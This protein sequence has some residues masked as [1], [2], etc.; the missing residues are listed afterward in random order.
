MPRSDSEMARGE[1][2][3]ANAALDRENESGAKMARPK[4]FELLS[5]SH[6]RDVLLVEQV[7][8]VPAECR[9]LGSFE[10]RAKSPTGVVALDLPTS[11]AMA[12][13][14]VDD[15]TARMFAAINDM[16]LDMLAAVA[17]K[18]YEDRRRRQMQGQTRAKVE[19]K[20]V[21]RPENKRR[22]KRIA[23]MLAAGTS[24]SD[25]QKATGCS[26]AT[27]AKVAKRAK[28]A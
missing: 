26:R 4:L 22:N 11:G 16:M 6:P 5:D 21:G 2:R 1:S 19:G 15:F 27:V 9:G 28:A 20:Y 8:A 3:H 23:D 7:S 12:T 14:K 24:Y 17:R 25:V 10:G 18:D 13:G